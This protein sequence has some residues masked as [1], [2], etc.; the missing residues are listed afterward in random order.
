MS[1]TIFRM[2]P[3]FKDYIWGGT[4]LRTKYGKVTDTDTV[5]ESWEVSCHKD[6]LSIIADGEKSGMTLCEYIKENPS[7]LGT[8]IKNGELPVLIKLIDARDN[9]SVQVHPNDEQAMLWEGQNGKTEMWYVVD[10]DKNA[11]ITFGLKQTVSKDCLKKSIEQNTVGDLLN[12]VNSKKGDVFFVKA[13]TI[14]AIGAG[15]LIA[16]IQQNSNV[17][18]RLYD[19]DRTG[20]DGKKRELHINKGVE[21]SDCN[22]VISANSVI[23]E[24]GARLLARC[25]YFTVREYTID[26]K[27]TL[28][29][30]DTSYMAILIT[31]GKVSIKGSDVSMDTDAGESVFVGAGRGELTLSG[32]G[33]ILVCTTEY[34]QK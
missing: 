4:K 24:S 12:T 25:E 30:D 11:K 21:A 27:I 10:A 23:A 8:N 9:L 5:A 18:Y 26:D 13:G 16:E 20:K 34:E 6:G 31:D 33:T 2:K 22:A 32:N 29:S 3:A 15:N 28:I 14:H 17:T 7:C 19:Y 1:R